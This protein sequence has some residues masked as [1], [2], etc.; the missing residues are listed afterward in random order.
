[1]TRTEKRE[2]KGSLKR[3][4]RREITVEDDEVTLYRVQDGTTRK[5][6]V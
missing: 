3:E 6:R 1:M 4:E 5:E 2:E